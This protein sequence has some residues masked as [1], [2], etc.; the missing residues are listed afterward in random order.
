M[1][2]KTWL[3]CAGLL[4]LTP[5]AIFAQARKPL[6]N[7]DI[8]S[9]TKQGFDAP[10]IEKAIP[11]G[12]SNF[13]V[14]AQALVA[15]QNAGVS[16]DVMAAMLSAHTNE[17]PAANEAAVVAVVTPNATT[18]DASKRACTPGNG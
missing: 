3:I 13:D 5:C 6:T 15:L 9:M 1:K 7:E 10:L 2:I 8:V 12:D 11:T 16:Q 18:M 4:A 14:S 17:P